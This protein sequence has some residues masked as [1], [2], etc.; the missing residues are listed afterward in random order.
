MSADHHPSEPAPLKNTDGSVELWRLFDPGYESTA[1]FAAADIVAESLLDGVNRPN[2]LAAIA[3]ANLPGVSS[4]EVQ[5]AI[6]AV[7]EKLGFESE[8]SGLFVDYPVS[9]LRPDFYRPLDQTGILFEVERGKTL[10]NNMDLLDL[11]KCHICPVASILFLF[12]PKLLQ[13]NDRQRPRPVLPA[14]VN[15]LET[16]FVAGNTTNVRAAFIFGY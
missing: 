2:V 1:E 16:F 3:R 4:H 5:T 13:Q 6:L 7:A 15:R 10:N 8:K 9:A 14:V 12:V 11:W